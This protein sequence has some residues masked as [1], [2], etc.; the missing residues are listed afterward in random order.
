MSRELPAGVAVELDAIE[1]GAP[2]QVGTLR[3]VPSS[4]GAVVA[5]AYHEAW[6]A[7]SDAF[8]ID[9]AHGL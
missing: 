8:V 4:V 7:R 5:F 3:R 2:V 1:L 6:L 9:P